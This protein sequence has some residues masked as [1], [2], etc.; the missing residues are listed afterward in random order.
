MVTV[1]TVTVVIVM[2]VIATEVIVI[3]VIVIVVC[4]S[5]GRSVR[6]SAQKIRGQKKLPYFFS[7]FFHKKNLFFLQ[8]KIVSPKSVF[9]IFFL[10]NKNLFKQK[11]R[12]LFTM[13][14]KQSLYTKK[15]RNHSKK[16]TQ[17][18]RKKIINQPP[19]K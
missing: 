1:V 2:V 18:L 3:V 5:I 4:P 7:S 15:S 9:T 12:K 14:I 13:K 11:S 8:K 6:L 17:P 19:E 16:I 10:F